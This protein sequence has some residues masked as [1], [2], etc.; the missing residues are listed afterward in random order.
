MDLSEA[1]KMV[2]KVVVSASERGVPVVGMKLDYDLTMLDAQSTRLHG[3]GLAAHG[4]SGPVFDAVVLDRHVDQY[5]KGSRTLAALC[6]HYG[7]EIVNAHDA[8]AD[9]IASIKVLLALGRG[10]RNCGTPNPRHCTNCRFRGTANGP[11]AMTSGAT[12]RAWPPSIHA[13]TSGRWHRPRRGT[14]HGVVAQALTTSQTMSTPSSWASTYLAGCCLSMCP[15][16][17]L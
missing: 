4:W 15:M 3:N 8:S 16:S 9:A 17:P 14:R 5:R 13:T 2:T 1:I 10:T 6:A 7:V 11:R 12:P